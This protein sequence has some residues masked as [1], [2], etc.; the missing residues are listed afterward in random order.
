MNPSI[1]T[2]HGVFLKI[3]TYGTLLTGKSQIGKS[4]LAFS[5]MHRGHQ[6]IAD[7]I[8]RL[9]RVDQQIIGHCPTELINKL[10]LREIGIINTKQ[11]FAVTKQHLTQSPINLIIKLDKK[12]LQM[13]KT[14]IEAK[15]TMSVTDIMGIKIPTFNLSFDQLDTHY[16]Q[17]IIESIVTLVKKNRLVTG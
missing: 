14:H 6:L 1:S 3:N 16:H 17:L 7:D 15:E 11:L 13:L 2:I 12:P 8:I 5:L 9:K 10:H 4:K